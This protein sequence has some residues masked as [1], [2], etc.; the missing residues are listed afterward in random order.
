MWL[1]LVQ[2]LHFENNC[3]SGT[4]ASLGPL[5]IWAIRW[6]IIYSTGFKRIKEMVSFILNRFKDQSI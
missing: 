3:P 4:A 1:L 2:R 5:P 6:I